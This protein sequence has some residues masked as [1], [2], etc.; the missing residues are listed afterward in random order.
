M[1]RSRWRVV[2]AACIVAAG[3]SFVIGM[4]AI[5]LDDRNAAKRDYIEYWAAGQ[6]LV[7]HASPYDLGAIL[8][9]ERSVGYEG[10]DVLISSSPPVASFLELPLGLVSTKVGLI[11]WLLALLGCLSASIFILWALH[12][13]PDTSFHLFGYMFAP[14]LACLMAG[15][16]GIFL[17][18]GIV[19]FLYFHKSCPFLA[20]A[21]LLPCALKPHL[22][23]PFA[24]TLLMWALGRKAY[25][26][27]AGFS[28]ALLASLA[29]TLCF[30]S[31]VWSHYAQMMRTT[32][33]LQVFVHVPTLSGALRFLF[34]RNT[35]WLQFLPEAA[36]CGWALWY[37]WTR[38]DRW[39]WMDEGMVMLL[40]SALCAPYA[41][42][43]DESMLLPAVLAGVYRAVD[44]RRSLVP[45]VLIAGVALIEAMEQTPIISSR[46]LWTTPAWLGWYLY[47]TRSKRVSAQEADHP[48]A[49]TN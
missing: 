17:L 28:A 4:F 34:A 21:V 25:G 2:A 22:F 10:S 35:L 7:H 29:L 40:V 26:I 11:L 37:F 32:T 33:V 36:G 44:S 6:L 8:R 19:L 20:G 43:T 9:L 41:W 1:K 16:I 15:Q 42:F 46:Y 23:L 31:H 47:A 48:A 24:V 45:I 39:N 49:Q 12:G 30:D 13:R 18:F 3:L 27:L 38:R 14:A 5:G